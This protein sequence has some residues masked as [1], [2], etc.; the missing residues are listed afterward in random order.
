MQHQVFD[1]LVFVGRQLELPAL[2][3]DDL[4][5]GIEGYCTTDKFADTAARFAADQG[6]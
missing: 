3:G 1:D 2:H 6:M 5:A 4:L